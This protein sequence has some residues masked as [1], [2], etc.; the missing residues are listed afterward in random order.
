M[1]NQPSDARQ[2][3]E[4]ASRGPLQA[5][6]RVPRVLVVIGMAALLVGG[7]MAP[8]AIGAVLLV[9]LGLFLAW[10]IALSWPVLTGGSRI[11]RLVTVALVFGAAYM[12]A[13]GRA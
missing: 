10:L 1:S 12:R 4:D 5:L 3:F 2:R 7:L 6:N 8:S 13:T 9:V 11:L